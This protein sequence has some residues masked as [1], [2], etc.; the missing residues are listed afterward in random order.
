LPRGYD[1]ELG[2][3]VRGL[4][5][6]QAQRVALARALY[7]DPVLLVLDEPNAHLD[8]DGEIALINTLKSA[9]ERGVCSVVV[10]HRAAFMS[11]ANKLM[12]VRDGR[13]EAFGPR[14]QIMKRLNPAASARPTAVP[15]VGEATGVRS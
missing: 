8:A 4:S 12:L 10:A 13:I 11:V 7:R 1:T 3:G 9:S 5:A 6:G 2:V 15:A 14:D